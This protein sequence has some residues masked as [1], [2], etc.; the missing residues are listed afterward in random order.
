MNQP[1]LFLQ[2]TILFAVFLGTAS[3]A[4]AQSDDKLRSEPNFE[5]NLNVL[6]G[7]NDAGRADLPAGLAGVTKQ[8]RS[9]FPYSSYRV[10]STF[11]GRVGNI[12]S[13]NYKSVADLLGPQTDGDP[14]TFLEWSVGNIRV[15]E[16]G[17]LAQS[18]RFGARVPVKTMITTGEPG[19]STQVVNYEAIGL[20]FARVGVPENV[21]TLLGTL[22]LPRTNG[23]LF[24][25]MTVTRAER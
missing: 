10:A 13:F 16:N 18:F 19:K 9:T 17:Y 3:I 25:V 1:K 7:S 8:L 5:I 23:T 2:L 20:N 14:A 6:I 15:V 11:M 21:P 4:S 22:T 24:L 12:G